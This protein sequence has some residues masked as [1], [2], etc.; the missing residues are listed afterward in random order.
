MNTVLIGLPPVP[1]VPTAL[2]AFKD[3][4]PNKTLAPR[5]LALGLLCG[6]LVVPSLCP[7]SSLGSPAPSAL[8]SRAFP[9]LSP[10][11]WGRPRV[12]VPSGTHRTAWVQPEDTDPL[13][14]LL[15]PFQASPK[16]GGAAPQLPCP[17]LAQVPFLAQRLPITSTGKVC[18]ANLQVSQREAAPETIWTNCPSYQWGTEASR[19]CEARPKARSSL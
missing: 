16:S 9:V 3:C 11:G 10:M 19:G 1:P 7:C 18:T 17:D 15:S 12:C 6:K 4:R 2:C 13:L 5:F 14:L 8:D